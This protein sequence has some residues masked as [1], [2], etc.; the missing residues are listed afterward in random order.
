MNAL[1]KW[2]MC[3]FQPAEETV[4]HKGK[5]GP[6]S[7]KKTSRQKVVYNLLLMVT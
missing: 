6:I 2:R 3:T 7:M 5:R 1:P 4:V